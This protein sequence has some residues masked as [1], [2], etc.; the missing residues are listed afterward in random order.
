MLTF[1]IHDVIMEPLFGETI[2]KISE[3]V[4]RLSCSIV[5]VGEISK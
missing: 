1:N 5:E 3:V 4:S 2:D